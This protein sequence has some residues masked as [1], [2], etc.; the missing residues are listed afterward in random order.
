MTTA[1]VNEAAAVADLLARTRDGVHISNAHTHVRLGSACTHVHDIV[2]KLLS[3]SDHSGWEKQVVATH[4]REERRTQLGPD[5]QIWQY[6]GLGLDSASPNEH[7]VPPPARPPSQQDW[8]DS[9][10]RWARLVAEVQ[11]EVNEYAG[12]AAEA[13]GLLARLAAGLDLAQPSAVAVDVEPEREPDLQVHDSVPPEPE[14][15]T[16]PAPLP[17]PM[18]VPV[19]PR[20][21]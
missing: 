10:A 12:V 4:T 1:W 15:E 11:T 17:V 9:V 13:D 14:P 19:V 16:V 18:P 20:E 8:E 3:P 21:L 2:S 6:A 5:W 7:Q